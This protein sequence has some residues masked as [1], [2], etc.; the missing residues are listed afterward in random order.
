MGCAQY[1]IA[2]Y[3]CWNLP[4]LAV[5]PRDLST[6][7][8]SWVWK[9]VQDT[10]SN[11]ESTPI[12]SGQGHFMELRIDCLPWLSR[13]G[14]WPCFPQLHGEHLDHGNCKVNLFKHPHLMESSSPILFWLLALCLFILA[15][16]CPPRA[17]SS[18]VIRNNEIYVPPFSSAHSGNINLGYNTL[19]QLWSHFK[20]FLYWI[21]SCH[22]CLSAEWNERGGEHF[23]LW[24]LLMKWNPFST[25]GPN[26]QTITTTSTNNKTENE[27]KGS[28]LSG[29]PRSDLQQAGL[30]GRNKCRI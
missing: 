14:R 1:A 11:L 12:T 22:Y 25:L 23:C 7:C 4:R 13:S 17:Q 18:N 5:F 9:G 20:L 16:S 3:C 15:P 29:R 21:T 2:I 28:R 26:K 8:F 27:S 19:K 30:N 10:L 6:C 24:D